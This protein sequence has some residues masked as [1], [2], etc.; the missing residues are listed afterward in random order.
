MAHH[1]PSP[2]PSLD[3]EKKVSLDAAPIETL[4]SG[5]IE[6][7]WF[8]S[9]LFQIIVVGMTSF[10]SPG[11]WNAM[12]GLGA[13]GGQNPTLA[14]GANSLVFA[15]MVVSCI[16]SSSIVDRIGYRWALV[17][18]SAL[19]PLYGGGQVYNLNTGHSWLVWVGSIGC[20]ASAGLF[21]GV[22]AAI[23]MGYPS[24]ETRGRYLALWTAFGQLGS[25]VGGSISLALN[26]GDGKAGSI[27]NTTYY[28]FIALQCIAPVVALFL[29][30]PARVLR[31][32]G[33]PVQMESHIGIRREL[34]EMWKVIVRPEILL[35]VPIVLRTEWPGSFA[36]TFEAVYLSVRGRALASLLTAILDVIVATL[37]GFYLDA[38]VLSKKTRARGSFLFIQAVFGGAWIW[39][40][41]LQ[42][43]YLKNPP[44]LDWSDKGFGAPFG[45]FL[46]YQLCYITLRNFLYWIVIQ[47]ARSP[48]DL[49][50]LSAFLRGLESVGAAVGFGISASTVP[51]TVPLGIN[52]G[53]WA[54]GLIAAWFVV[55]EVREGGRYEGKEGEK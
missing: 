36:G 47:L 28:V 10:L 42:V 30:E 34:K 44:L 50:R 4:T 21:W 3:E 18:G 45:A 16:F 19:Y 31:S 55:K 11:F 24:A 5:N 26:A 49:L 43:R 40:T 38:Q 9:V 29:S 12:N 53:L 51:Y 2:A 15:L 39:F 48:A 22:E 35:L 23:V 7:S 46:I 41:I 54:L 25:V 8:R 20:G 32:D 27:T 37:L 6:K 52:F 14:N 1:K 33:T 13:A 17:F